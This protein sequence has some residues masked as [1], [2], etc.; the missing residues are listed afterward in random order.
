MEVTYALYLV[1]VIGRGGSAVLAGD[2]PTADMCQESAVTALED[3]ARHPRLRDA[4]CV[5]VKYEED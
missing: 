4:F 2:Y 5:P 1:F 3:R